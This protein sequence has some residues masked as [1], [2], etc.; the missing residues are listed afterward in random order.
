MFGVLHSVSD[1]RCR[2]R[3]RLPWMIFDYIDGAAGQETGAEAT[4]QAFDALHLGT[5]QNLKPKLAGRKA[6]FEN[7]K[8]LDVFEDRRKQFDAPDDED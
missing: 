7:R 4:R 3:R 1:A 8:I 2:A 5:S 6:V